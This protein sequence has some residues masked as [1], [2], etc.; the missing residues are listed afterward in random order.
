MK[1]LSSLAV[2]SLLVLGA[3]G[4]SAE[5]VVVPGRRPIRPILRPPVVLP[6]TPVIVPGTPVVIRPIVP[7]INVGLPTA[8]MR[9]IDAGSAPFDGNEFRFESVRMNY[10]VASHMSLRVPAHCAIKIQNFEVRGV[11]GPVRFV[12]DLSRSHS[13][14]YYNFFTY[15]IDRSQRGTELDEV[16]LGMWSNIYYYPQQ[17]CGVR[18][19][20]GQ[21]RPLN[22][23]E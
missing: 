1:K 15:K 9:W 6:G 21:D 12:T 7:V 4:A 18:V 22:R 20:L 3:A 19:F 16:V 23:L 2:L 5:V 14:G 10:E 13:N 8:D 17:Q 11:D